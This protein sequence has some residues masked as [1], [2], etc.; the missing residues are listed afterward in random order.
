M[1][2]R[3][4][5]QIDL[6]QAVR[7]YR[8]LHSFLHHGPSQH[9]LALTSRESADDEGPDMSLELADRAVDCAFMSTSPRLTFVLRGG[10]PLMVSDLVRHVVEYV[11][12]KNRLARKEV[13]FVLQTPV[14][15]LDEEMASCKMIG[16]T[17][18]S[19]EDRQRT[20]SLR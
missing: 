20:P 4:T 3:R 12:D 17:V 15:T 8:N 9:V 6:D 19:R 13:R 18:R 5:E 14:T 11:E 2:L 16:S 1:P 10:D 7:R